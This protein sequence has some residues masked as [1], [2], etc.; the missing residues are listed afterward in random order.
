MFDFPEHNNNYVFSKSDEYTFFIYCNKGITRCGTYEE[1][2]KSWPY[3]EYTD[4]IPQSYDVI[5]LAEKLALIESGNII[6]VNKK[7]NNYKDSEYMIINSNEERVRAV[8]N[9]KGECI[10]FGH[11]SVY[12][13]LYNLEDFFRSMERKGYDFWSA[14]SDYESHFHLHS[15]CMAFSQDVI[16]NAQF[17]KFWRSVPFAYDAHNCE[18]E[19]TPLLT[20][21][22]FIGNSYIRT[23]KQENIL[24]N[25]VQM[26]QDHQAPQHQRKVQQHEQRKGA[27]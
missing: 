9:T 4:K 21:Q 15:Y 18:M 5:H 6:W 12:G 23:F 19:L 7:E 25:P 16:K 3:N 1:L 17:H 14:T 20:E 2:H 26:L 22:G 8:V 24:R 27:A 10:D 13:P 11:D